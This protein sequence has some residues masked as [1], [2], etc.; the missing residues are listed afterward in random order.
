M[1]EHLEKF[2]IFL[3]K[4]RGYSEFT[5]N[6]YISDLNQ[7]VDFLTFNRKKSFPSVKKIT[8]NSI[9]NFI[10]NLSRRGLS[11][12]SIRRKLS[13]LRTFFKFLIR[14]EIIVKDPIAVIELPK[15]EKKLPR[16]LTE[17]E[18][19]NTIDSIE[20][21]NKFAIR[22]I[23]IIELIYGCGLRLREVEKLNIEDINNKQKIVKVLGKGSKERLV[24]LG[25]Y[26]VK[27]IKDYLSV[28]GNFKHKKKLDNALFLNK[29]GGRI[30][31]R[32]IQRIIEKRFVTFT[33]GEIIR[34]HKL[35]HSFASHM[36]NKGADIRGVKELLGHKSLSTTQ[37]Y[38]HLTP[39][40]I[41]NIYK[42]AHPRSGSKN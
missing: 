3:K 30:S 9:K 36:V 14:E 26:A 41:K 31:A 29:Y 23:A 7:F 35:R 8:T 21:D 25:N 15:I 1:L 28:R 42:K 4:E 17:K 18:I 32:S 19:E 27:A 2:K 12:V 34:P 16:F 37:I 5:I 11:N 6:S 20:A 10:I 13:S 22:D 38:T 24:P 33:E 39:E 40:R